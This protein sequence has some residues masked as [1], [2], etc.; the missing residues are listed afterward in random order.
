MKSLS[1]QTLSLWLQISTLAGC[2]NSCD[3][4]WT[5]SLCDNN[6]WTPF[7][8]SG[9]RNGSAATLWTNERNSQSFCTDV[10]PEFL[11]NYRNKRIKGTLE[12]QTMTLYNPQTQDDGSQNTFSFSISFQALGISWLCRNKRNLNTAN[13]KYKK[14]P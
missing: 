11:V 12:Q 5:V 1:W 10:Y 9:I 4:C 6:P 14:H 3:I 13:H 7:G 2:H 8:L